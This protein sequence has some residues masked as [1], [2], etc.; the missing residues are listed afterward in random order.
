IAPAPSQRRRVEAGLRCAFHAGLAETEPELI[1]QPPVPLDQRE[2][3][4]EAVRI[5][6]KAG[7]LQRQP[8]HRIVAGD[9]P[10]QAERVSARRWRGGAEIVDV[11]IAE[12]VR[13]AWLG[14]GLAEL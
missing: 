10:A 5:G 9:V 14:M 13:Y 2:L 12:R 1:F 8:A 3:V 6:Q 11:A 4:M 7:R